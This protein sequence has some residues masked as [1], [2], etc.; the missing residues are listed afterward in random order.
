MLQRFMEVLYKE[1]MY[2]LDAFFV[3]AANTYA[4]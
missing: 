4:L 3:V 2:I 1:F